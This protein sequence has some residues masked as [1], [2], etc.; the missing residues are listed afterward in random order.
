IAVRYCAD[1]GRSIRADPPPPD[2]RTG[3]LRQPLRA[4]APPTI[5]AISTAKTVPPS[6]GGVPVLAAECPCNDDGDD[7]LDDEHGRR[8]LPTQRRNRHGEVVER[9]RGAGNG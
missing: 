6:G 4:T 8:D 2:V 3:V 9:R 1:R 7:H 5:K